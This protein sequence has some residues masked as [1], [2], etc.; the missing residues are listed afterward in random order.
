[1]AINVSNQNNLEQIQSN[2]VKKD[3][4]VAGKNLNTAKQSINLPQQK[5]STESIESKTVDSPKPTK[6]I[7]FGGRTF[8]AGAS[9]AKFDTSQMQ[10]HARKA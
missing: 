7:S 4:S 10:D 5:A 6:A 8:G 1:M 9:E 3:A 2:N